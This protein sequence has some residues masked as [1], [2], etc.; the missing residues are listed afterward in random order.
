MPAG[1]SPGRETARA[2][3]PLTLN[4]GNLAYLV[5]SLPI[6]SH[7]T[8][9]TF[10]SAGLPCVRVRYEQARTGVLSRAHC[11]RACG[12]RARDQR[13]GTQDPPPARR[14]VSGPGR[15]PARA[16]TAGRRGLGLPKNLPTG[17]DLCL[18]P[19]RAALSAPAPERSSISVR[20]GKSGGSGGKP[21]FTLITANSVTF[22][23][24]LPRPWPSDTFRQAGSASSSPSTG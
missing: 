10:G 13:R 11:R 23:V 17:T 22:R 20:K 19:A 21:F 2:R 5:E 1:I 6:I 12:G 9:G 8:G 14:P 16:G 3:P 15:R 4:V 18:N 7:C 24:H